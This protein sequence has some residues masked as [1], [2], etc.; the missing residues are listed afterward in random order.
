MPPPPRRSPAARRRG[1]REHPL[2]THAGLDTARG[3]WLNN[4]SS[5]ANASWLSSPAVLDQR[6]IPHRALFRGFGV[7]SLLE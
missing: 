7:L 4:A 6:A 3:S 2:S 5:A 1:L